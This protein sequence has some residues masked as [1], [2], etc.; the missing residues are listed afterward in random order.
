MVV[1]NEEFDPKFCKWLRRP[2]DIQGIERGST[3]IEALPV[4]NANLNEFWDSIVALR[5]RQMKVI[6]VFT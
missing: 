2:E 3:I 6:T 5:A 4:L 1:D